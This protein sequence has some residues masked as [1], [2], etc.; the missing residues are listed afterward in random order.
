MI[1]NFENI[2]EELTEDE[3]HF[4]PSM[5][6]GFKLRTIEN[7]IT[8]KEICKSIKENT[9]IKLTEPR[10]RK[11]VNHIRSNSILPLIATSRGYYCSYDVNEI[12]EQIHSLDQRANSIH[13]AKKGLLKFLEINW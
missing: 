3:M 8:G 5:I 2:T 9:G 7:P 13:Q 10:L 11:F 12:K 6:A 4:L 1:T